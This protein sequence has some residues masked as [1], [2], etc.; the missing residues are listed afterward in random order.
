MSL[1]STAF[2]HPLNRFQK[3][4]YIAPPAARRSYSSHAVALHAYSPRRRRGVG[5]I[6]A[7]L[8][9]KVQGMG[10][11][12]R[13]AHSNCPIFLSFNYSTISRIKMKFRKRNT[14]QTNVDI[15]HTFNCPSIGTK[16]ERRFYYLDGC[17]ARDNPAIWI[18]QP[19]LR[20]LQQD[21]K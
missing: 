18:H 14:R 8:Q 2:S 13:V 16:L 19:V 20:T 4:V 12:R 10:C 21:V 6:G 15:R 11:G 17:I 7:P 5:G 1:A 9:I 3:G